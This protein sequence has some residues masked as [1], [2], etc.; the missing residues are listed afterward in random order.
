M[1]F[2][3]SFSSR[4]SKIKETTGKFT[5]YLFSIIAMFSGVLSADFNQ[6]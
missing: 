5:L 1:E 3:T 6:K 4:G 2:K